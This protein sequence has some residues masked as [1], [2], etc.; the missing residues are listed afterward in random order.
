[1][2][3]G[4]ELINQPIVA[5]DTGCRL[6]SVKDLIFS[7]DQSALIALL[8]VEPRWFRDGKI[9]P[10]SHIKSIGADAILVKSADSILPAKQVPAVNSLLDRENILRGTEI[11][12]ENGSN[13]GKMID[14]YFDRQT[15]AVE[16]Y[17]VSGGV[18]ADAYTGRSFVPASETLRIGQDF[19]FVS[20]SVIALMEEQVGGIKAVITP[21]SDQAQELA[22]QA[23]EKAQGIS[24]AAA[25]KFTEVQNKAVSKVHEAIATPAQK[26]KFA[27]GRPIESDVYHPNGSIFLQK[28][29]TIIP[30]DLERAEELGILDSL[31]EA[32][33]GSIVTA[34]KHTASQKAD[35]IAQADFR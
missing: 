1:M 22:Q 17:E 12:T 6:A 10:F 35:E 29:Q 14:L 26:K 34:A 8:V 19:A 30:S 2:R 20:N 21:I 7:Q 24:A 15:G 5:Y 16:G 13:L 3:K 32:A 9:V 25:T 28:H 23:N 4:T 33:G 18:F 31:Y 11:M 27:L